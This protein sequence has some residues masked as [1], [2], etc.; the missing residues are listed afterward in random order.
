MTD[1]QG[2]TNLAESD[3][4]PNQVGEDPG[5]INRPGDHD[6]GPTNTDELIDA[7]VVDRAHEDSAEDAD[8]EGGEA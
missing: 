4:G 8:S 7:Q 1:E 2:P 3:P 5:P 6:P